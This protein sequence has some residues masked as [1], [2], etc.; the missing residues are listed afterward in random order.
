MIGSKSTIVFSIF[1]FMV[2]SHAHVFDITKFGAKP[3]SE[4]SKVK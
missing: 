2:V 1:M 3:G 4:I